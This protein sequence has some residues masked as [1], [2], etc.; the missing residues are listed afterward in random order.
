MDKGILFTAAMAVISILVVLLI[1][2]A[3]RRLQG[4]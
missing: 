3:R 1:I 2:V 4:Y